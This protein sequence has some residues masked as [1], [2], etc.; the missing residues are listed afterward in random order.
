MGS[1][2]YSQKEDDSD[3]ISS[4]PHFLRRR[5]LS[6]TPRRIGLT[7]A[8]A[9]AAT[10]FTVAGCRHA[11]RGTMRRAGL[12]A[13]LLTSTVWLSAQQPAAPAQNAPVFRSSADL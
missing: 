13:F 9:P 6:A 4:R 8:F 11:R 7:S 2:G 1:G 5:S 10:R 12:F 3:P